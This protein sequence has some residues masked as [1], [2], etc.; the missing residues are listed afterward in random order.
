MNL[1]GVWAPKAFWLV[2]WVAN[3]PSWVSWWFFVLNRRQRGVEVKGQAL[4]S[5]P[6]SE[7]CEEGWNPPQPMR[8]AL[9]GARGLA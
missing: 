5:V 6:L 9:R 4:L 1:F 2:S 3:L 7:E 8:V